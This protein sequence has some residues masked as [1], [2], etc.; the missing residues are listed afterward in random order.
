MRKENWQ[1]FSFAAHPG[2]RGCIA[3]V[4]FELLKIGS[5]IL[6]IIKANM[7]VRIRYFTDLIRCCGSLNAPLNEYH[8]VAEF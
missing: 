1:K 8:V 3:T 6:F 4:L 7:S 2:V 5:V